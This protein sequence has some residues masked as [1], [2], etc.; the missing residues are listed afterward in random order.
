MITKKKKLNSD[1]DRFA[2]FTKGQ[3]TQLIKKLEND[4]EEVL[5]VLSKRFKN[6]E[7]LR[8]DDPELAKLFGSI[9]DFENNTFIGSE[10]I[11][12]EVGKLVKPI[13]VMLSKCRDLLGKQVFFL[14]TGF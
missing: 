11:T 1:E 10:F 12:S 6:R 7:K 2:R 4:L 13:Y 5:S 14:F 9:S 3:N 8:D